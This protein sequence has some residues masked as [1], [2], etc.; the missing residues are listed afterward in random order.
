MTMSDLKIESVAKDFWI[1][2]R[3]RKYL[4]VI[5]LKDGL[6]YAWR[7]SRPVSFGKETLED[8]ADILAEP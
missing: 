3:D 4:G 5:R 7:D 6:Y 8:A 1:V 2:K